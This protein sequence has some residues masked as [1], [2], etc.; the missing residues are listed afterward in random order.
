M[1]TASELADRLIAGGAPATAEELLDLLRHSPREE[2]RAA[3]H[4]VTVAFAPKHFDFCSIVNARSGRCPENCKWCAQSA[5]WKTGCDCHGWIG[6]EACARA[7]KEAEANG[8]DRIGI[9]TSGRAQTPADIDALC[10]ALRAMRRESEID[11]CGSLGLVSE[12]DL[13]RLR[14]AG[15]KRLHCNLETAPSLFPA[16]CSTHT[17]A[18][19]LETLR[20]ARRLGMQICCGGIVGMGETDEQ[21]VEFALALR[22]IAPDSIPVNFLHPIPGTPLGVRGVPDPERAVDAVAVLRLAN[23]A[24]P[25]RFAGGRRDMTDETARR[26]VWC[27]IDAGIAGPLLTT[28]GAD[29]DDDRALAR[30]AGYDVTPPPARAKLAALR[31]ALRDAGSALVAFSAGVDSTFLLRVAH[32]ELGDGAVAATIRAPFVSPREIEEA[33]AF[34]RSE[35][36]GHVVV[37]VAL[38]DVPQFAENPPDRCYHCKKALFTRL[39]A[40]AE[41]RGLATVLEGSNVDDDGDY[42]P[43]ARAIRELGIRSPLRDAGLTKAEIRALSRELGLPTADKPSAACLASRIP[44]GN[45]ITPELLFRVDCAEAIL[46]GGF[47]DLAQLRVRVHGDL[48]RIEVPVADIPRLASHLADISFA[49]RPLGFVDVEIDPRG[50][51]TGSLNEALAGATRREG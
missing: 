30:E 17:Q 50:Y 26:A 21:L 11:L 3:A 6:A 41:E 47:P 9:V 8:A 34:C 48:A 13:R 7:A 35:G 33:V 25:L 12:E 37:D 19:K 15:L 16:L 22:E 29:F 31:S 44:Y 20:A 38:A 2:L 28:P 1:N 27:G 45:R 23:P 40:L 18:Q 46:R 43:G 5:H 10:D 49:L 51:R 36:I 14:D 42:R 32:E 24:T 39:L 4:R